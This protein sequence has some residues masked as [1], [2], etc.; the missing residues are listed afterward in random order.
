MK[1]L[2]IRLVVFF[3]F[4]VL[5]NDAFASN[6]SFGNNVSACLNSCDFLD[7]KQFKGKSGDIGICK[8]ES[9]VSEYCG[10]DTFV[11]SI[12]IKNYSDFEL[13]SFS[14]S[15]RLDHYPIASKNITE[16]LIAGDSVLIVF[17][18]IM[19][20]SGN[21]AIHFQCSI[22]GEMTDQNLIN[23]SYAYSFNYSAGKKVQISVFTD[24]FGYETSWV[25]KNSNDLIIAE[26]D[27]FDS[28]SLYQEVICLIQGC[29][30]FSIYDD[31]GDGMCC[32]YGDGYYLL[33][34]ITDGIEIATGGDYTTSESI[35]FCIE[36]DIGAPY[37]SFIKSGVNNCT[38]GV[39]FFDCS[40]CNPPA[41]EWF[42]DF[43]DGHTSFE[44]NPINNYMMNGYYDV[45]L[46][47]TNEYGVSLLQIPSY[48]EILRSAPPYIADEYFCEEG[49]II[50]FHA[51]NGYDDISWYINP[52]S[53]NPELIYNSFTLENLVID[54]TIYYQYVYN[55][56]S[57]YVGLTDNS[58]VGGYFNFSIDRAV[59]FDAYSDLTI[60][61][62]RVF[63][64][65]TAERTITLKNSGGEILDTRTLNITDGESIINLD[66]Q[67]EAGMDYALHVNLLNNLSYSGDYGGSNIGYPFT[68]PSL[69][70]FTGNNYSDS[71]W[72]FFYDI[73]VMEGF[74]STCASAIV[75]LHAF[76][77]Q[78][79]FDI[80]NDTTI[81][82]RSEIFLSPDSE[83]ADYLWSNDSSNFEILVSNPGIYSLT[84]TDIHSCTASNTI[85]IQNFDELVYSVIIENYNDDQSG[86]LSV[87][88]ASGDEPVDIIWDDQT[89]DL[90]K[91]DLSPGTYY[92]TLTDDNGCEYND[93]A[94]VM[95][96][97]NTPNSL[98]KSVI[99][100]PNPV[101]DYLIIESLQNQDV[102]IQ[103]LDLSGRMVKT[104]YSDKLK[105]TIDMSDINSGTYFINIVDIK[106]DDYRYKIV[107]Q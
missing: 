68:L 41:T 6:I 42:W 80:G 47:I 46:Q 3:C 54:S 23:N 89:T 82:P 97:S 1:N 100:Y 13:D 60:K 5:I 62:A 104:I 76:L 86:S 95:D 15:Y 69:I 52:H 43:G 98:L 99:V 101:Y 96:L 57:Q 29:Y 90:F 73:E 48:V 74:N 36:N 79:S 102:V 28:N 83:F 2:N 24:N 85:A 21:H 72:Y 18:P 77:S 34:N 93:S 67:V 50:V 61:T 22:L 30:T 88:I 45:S 25:L 12:W 11:P 31:Y 66:F 91:S 16:L 65:G 94:T 17:D 38:G 26:G 105:T 35:E 106:N 49:E 27:N 58:G 19:I 8:V 87:E 92:F 70:S 14:V 56:E 81:C 107:K 64:S 39:Q 63:A 103:L 44:Q 75:P 4:I 37:A 71:F 10:Y 55:V 84:V 9:P 51:P 32:S 7:N 40:I 53:D 59:Y 20:N 33:E 78:P